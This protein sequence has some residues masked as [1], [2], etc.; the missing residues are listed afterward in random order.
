MRAVGMPDGEYEFGGHKVY[1]KGRRATLSDGTIAASVSNLYECM[2]TCIKD[3]KVPIESAVRAATI[4]A[5]RS[6][7]MDRM[8]GSITKG[9]YADALIIDK[10]TLELKK[11]IL[12]GNVL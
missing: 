6:V 4:N 5:A 12:R 3:I 8:Y 7:R 11:V 10:D 9:K 1:V 2:I